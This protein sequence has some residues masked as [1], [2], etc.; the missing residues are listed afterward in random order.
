M[1]RKLLSLLLALTLTCTAFAA[2]G[3]PEDASASGSAETSKSADESS[4]ASSAESAKENSKESSIEGSQESTGAGESSAETL[5]TGSSAASGEVANKD[6]SASSSQAA[7]SSGA[8]APSQ[9]PAPSAPAPTAPPSS[10]TPAVIDPSQAYRS[11][12]T[13]EWISQ[14]IQNQRPVAIMVDNEKTALDHYGLTQADIVYEMMNSTA[15]DEVTRLMCI[16]KDWGS[17]SRFGSIRSVRPTNFMIA[18]EY[19][20]VL[21]HDGGPFYINDYLANPWVNN[22]SGGF[23]RIDNGKAREFTEYVTT[24]ELASRMKARNYSTEYNSY[25]QGQQWQFADDANLGGYGDAF[26]CS[27]VDLPF[28]HNA[29]QLDYDSASNTYLYSEY[30]RAHIDP[31]NGNKQLAFTNV[32]VQCADMTQLDPNGYMQFNVQNASGSGYYI[33]GGMAIPVTWSKAGATEPTTFY[34][35]NGAEITLHTGKT[36]IALVASYRWGE[37]ALR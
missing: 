18:P 17:I 16:V 36:Y 28:P 20:A 30:G 6:A 1:K 37:L 35:S 11:E 4:D 31:Q 15:N 34:D 14:T 3:N 21:V 9:P 27:Q 25:Y 5:E 23:A 7:A 32:I 22:L 12:L 8:A 19:N 29:S 2:C 33:T 24:G 13:N 10:Y 26:G